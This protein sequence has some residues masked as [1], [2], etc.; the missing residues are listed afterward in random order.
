MITLA[1]LKILLKKNLV[2]K[3]NQANPF[4]IENKL[5]ETFNK[6]IQNLFILKEIH[7]QRSQFTWK[8]TNKK[9]HYKNK[10]LKN[11]DQKKSQ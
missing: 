9:F 1:A 3:N 10:K 5:T 7:C 4:T 2:E 8:K 6:F 11:Q